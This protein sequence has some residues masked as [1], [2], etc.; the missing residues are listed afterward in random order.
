MPRSR[1]RGIFIGL[2]WAVIAL[3]RGEACPRRLYAKAKARRPTGRP[4][5]TWGYI[6]PVGTAESCDLLILPLLWLLICLHVS[7]RPSRRCRRNGYIHNQRAQTKTASIY[8]EAVLG[9]T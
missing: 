8:I 1:D 2:L 3:C 5:R 7:G 6:P 4:D 9:A